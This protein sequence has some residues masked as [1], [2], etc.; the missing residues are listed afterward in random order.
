MFE[1]CFINYESTVNQYDKHV[2]YRGVI[3][4][5][6]INLQKRHPENKNKPSSSNK[7]LKTW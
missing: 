7:A 2:L 3:I 1:Q 6:S 4:K 5:M